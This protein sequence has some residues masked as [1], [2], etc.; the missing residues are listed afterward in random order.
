MTTLFFDVT[1]NH[2]VQCIPGREAEGCFQ[3]YELRWQGQRWQRQWGLQQQQQSQRLGRSIALG[4]CQCG[5]TKPNVV[6]GL[7][8]REGG[9]IPTRRMMTCHVDNDVD[10]NVVNN[11]DSNSGNNKEYNDKNNKIRTKTKTRTRMTVT[12]LFLDVTTNLV[13]GC[14]PGRDGEGGLFQQCQGQHKQ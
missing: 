1:T 14:I 4:I 6:G 12:A 2:V 8:G 3:Q 11:I 9:V 7:P 5:G 13:V 10:N